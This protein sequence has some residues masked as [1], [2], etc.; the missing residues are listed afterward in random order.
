MS[1][2]L[3]PYPSCNEI[4]ILLIDDDPSSRLGLSGALGD[5]GHKVFAFAFPAQVPADGRLL[6]GTLLVTDYEM[7]GENGMEFADRFHAARPDVPV[8]LMTAFRTHASRHKRPFARFSPCSPSRSTTTSST[9]CFT[10][11]S[12]P[13]RSPP[14]DPSGLCRQAARPD[15]TRASGSAR[16]SARVNTGPSVQT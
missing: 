13:D 7:P 14:A 6:D 8:V 4:P 12:P 16:S 2:S 5:D 15:S 3:L 10:S 11:S 9:Y 1:R